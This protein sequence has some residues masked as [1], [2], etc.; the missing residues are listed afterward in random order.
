MSV[1]VIHLSDDERRRLVRLAQC[2][3]GTTRERDIS[4]LAAMLLTA[5]IEETLPRAESLRRA[6]RAHETQV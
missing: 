1:L 4:D 5:A 2:R 6:L 3:L